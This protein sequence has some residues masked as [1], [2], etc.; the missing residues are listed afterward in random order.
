ME[1]DGSAAPLVWQGDKERSIQWMGKAHDERSDYLVYLA[2]GPWAD[3]LRRDPRFLRL[4]QLISHG[5]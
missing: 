3:P 4:V 2:T 5:Q 1:P